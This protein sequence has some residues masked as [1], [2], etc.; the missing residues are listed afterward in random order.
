MP[1]NH[2]VPYDTI[3]RIQNVYLSP[4]TPAYSGSL[5]GEDSKNTMFV[6]MGTAGI[7]AKNADIIFH[8]TNTSTMSGTVSWAEM[9]IFTGNFSLLG[10]ASL[11]KRG[12]ADVQYLLYRNATVAS[13]LDNI[14]KVTLSLDPPIRPGE[15][16]WFSHGISAQVMPTFISCLQAANGGH[17]NNMNLGAVQLLNNRRPST[18]TGPFTTTGLTNSAMSPPILAYLS[19]Y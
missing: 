2:S 17:I 16:I 10:T 3:D 18:L 9:G 4:F 13:S 1:H 7:P 15:N 19:L 6:Y 12:V 14:K 11:T 8:P 5:T